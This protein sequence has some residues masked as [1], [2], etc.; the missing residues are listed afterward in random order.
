MVVSPLIAVAVI[1]N[2]DSV[3]FAL[4]SRQW[5]AEGFVPGRTIFFC[6]PRARL[7]AQGIDAASIIDYVDLPYYRNNF[8]INDKKRAACKAIDAKFIYL[9]HDRF[10]PQRGLLDTLTRALAD[11]DIDF[12]AVDVDNPDGTPALREHRLKRAAVNVDIGSALEPLGRLACDKADPAASKHIAINGGQFFLRKALAAH[13]DRPMRWVEMEDEVLSHDLRAARGGWIP[14]CRL[15][16]AVPRLAPNFGH[17]Y[18]TKLKFFVYRIA[19]NMLA[20]MT[21]SISVG[22]HL[23]RLKLERGLADH[24]LLVDPLHKITSTDFLP[25]SL[26]KIMTRARV[27][28]NGKCWARVDKLRFGWKLTGIKEEK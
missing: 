27:E 3:H 19:C 18:G 1:T 22:Q 20:A 11:N 26:E 21:N 8:H 10:F 16:T 17:A 25:S 5:C 12:G 9:V 14:G 15:V 2:G 24:I 13:L 7:V 4:T 6:G 23:D 28:S